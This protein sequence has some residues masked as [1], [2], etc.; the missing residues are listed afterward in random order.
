VKPTTF[1]VPGGSQEL[2]FERSGLF[3][4][5]SKIVALRAAL[6]TPPVDMSVDRK[7]AGVLPDNNSEGHGVFI[8]SFNASII[9]ASKRIARPSRM[10]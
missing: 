9:A 6:D 10:T 4:G 2:G 3:A 8:A 7:R 1:P 5:E